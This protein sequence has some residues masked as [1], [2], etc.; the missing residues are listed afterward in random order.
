MVDST[1]KKTDTELLPGEGK[2]KELG[3]KIFW[4]LGEILTYKDTQGL[5]PKW[6][7]S[8]E[9]C[10]NKHW[11]TK[12]TKKPLVSANMIGA[13][14]KKTTNMLTNNNPTFNVTRFGSEESVPE[15]QMEMAL[16]TAENWWIE[17][18]QQSV[19]EDSVLNGETYGCT[20]EKAVFNRELEYGMG[21]VETEIIEPF[22]YGT[23]PVKTKDVQK[24]EANLHY[25]PMALREVRRLWPKSSDKVQA[26]KEYISKLQ[27]TRRET[28]GKGKSDISFFGSIGGVVKHFI[29]PASDGTSGEEEETLVVECWVKDRTEVS[30]SMVIEDENGLPV[31]QIT[32]IPKYTGYIRKVVCCNGGE[33]ILEDVS[34]PSINPNLDP[35][36]AQQTYL[37]DKYP[38]TR[39]PSNKDNISPW[40]MTDIEQLDGL[41]A[42]INKSLSQFTLL[43][44]RN[45]RPKIINPITS[46][47]SNDRFTNA[48][49]IINPSNS[50][51]AQAI[52]Y[53]N[54]PEI[55]GDIL[56]GLS[57]YKDFFY[58]VSGAFEL[59]NAQTPGREV[60]AY[61]A[62]A[63][64]IEHAKTTEQGKI[65]NYSKMIRERGRMYLSLAQNWY[66]EERWIA[67]DD[68][69]ESTSV[70]ITG[71]DLIAPV[72]LTVVSG[73]TM[74]RSQVQEREEAIELADKGHIDS[75][76]LLKSLEFDGRK[77][78]LKRKKQGPLGVLAESLAVMGAP[79]QFTQF[80]MELGMME[81]DKA[82]KAIESGDMP[83]FQQLLE[84]APEGEQLSSL[85]VAE[86]DKAAAEIE[87]T[88]AETML[89]KEKIRTEQAD[90]TAKLH[91]ID[92]D[93][94]T[95]QLNKY[96]AIKDA[97]NRDKVVEISKTS[98]KTSQ[99]PYRE[100]GMTSNNIKQ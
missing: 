67:Y 68:D 94:E 96:K 66:T 93:Q 55:P 21:E 29:N 48:P 75:E 10:K 51:E 34:N 46:G 39:T 73:S 40:G 60:I 35:E 28:A 30:E 24:C 99:G 63:A 53:M 32:T 82:E 31:E 49:G 76:A 61:K 6:V 57:L 15:E 25:R 98:N 42:E 11:K 16:H 43:K 8:Y 38:F 17:Q 19:L 36:L 12:H 86:L 79:E 20:I 5:P 3:K 13:H 72:K 9:L 70:K 2:P 22:H 33:V 59:E 52:R 71:Q 85:D 27:D 64:L 44:D 1:L 88:Q 83:S 23:Y 37:W 4:I 87:K 65:R 97:D 91:G 74:P 95:L 69:T 26:D 90:Q 77:E 100:K 89:I 50:M 58:A 56:E 78:I 62:I 84:P 92:L 41:Q 81:P 7:K 54:G 80:V 45:S 47:V 14:R 18:E